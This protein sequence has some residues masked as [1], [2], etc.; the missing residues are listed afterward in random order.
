MRIRDMQKCLIKL[1]NNLHLIVS[2]FVGGYLVSNG[3]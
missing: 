3:H 2:L 1:K